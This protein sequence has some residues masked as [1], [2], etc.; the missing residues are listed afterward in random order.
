MFG[1]KG[2]IGLLV[3]ANNG[4]L[5]PELWSRLPPEVAL[6]ATR[7]L[8]RGDLTPK[9][10]RSMEQQVDRGVEELYQLEEDPGEKHNRASLEPERVT[11]LRA[12]LEARLLAWQETALAEPPPMTA[13]ESQA[14]RKR[15][16]A[17]GYTDQ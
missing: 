3:P 16:G 10:V 17:M 12:L 2:R 15:I 7:L 4:V 9:A 14:L 13:E 5:E 1:A 11:A 8:A 6:Y